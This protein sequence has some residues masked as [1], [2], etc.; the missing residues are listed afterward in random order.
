MASR[1]TRAYKS[2]KWAKGD[3]YA[4]KRAQRTER[5]YPE[6]GYFRPRKRGFSFW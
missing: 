5:N 4:R 6:L 3:Y 2:G 1:I